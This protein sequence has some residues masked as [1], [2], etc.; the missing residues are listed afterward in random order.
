[1]LNW[2]N[3]QPLPEDLTKV[4][5][6]NN[7]RISAQDWSNFA[8]FEQCCPPYTNGFDQ[9]TQ[10]A[11]S[12]GHYAS[13][14]N[15]GQQFGNGYHGG[16]SSVY[17]LFV[18]CWTRID[19]Q[20]N[21]LSKLLPLTRNFSALVFWT[22]NGNRT[23]SDPSGMNHQPTGFVNR[24]NQFS[25]PGV[26]QQTAAIPFGSPNFFPNAQR[27]S[28]PSQ[29]PSFQL[30]NQLN[31][32]L[33]PD[34]YQQYPGMNHFSRLHSTANDQQAMRSCNAHDRQAH[35]P[36]DANRNPRD[37]PKVTSHF[38]NHFLFLFIWPVHFC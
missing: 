14:A 34:H 25:M 9:K 12:L 20:V 31:P 21:G 16:K 29:P 2:N 17:E 23:W 18:I 24:Y 22:V 36:V 28:Q 5:E 15:G 35:S 37:D 13:T 33:H 19:L 6:V 27:L 38:V 3:P 10:S 26:P 32:A 8:H 1:M 11:P 4:P 7:A 30:S